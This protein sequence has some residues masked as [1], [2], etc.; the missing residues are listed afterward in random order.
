M[1]KLLL[2]LVLLLVL[3]VSACTN[4]TAEPT[5]NNPQGKPSATA[6]TIVYQS[7]NGPIHI[8]AR[9]K[10]II[11]L[12]NAPNVLALGG[13]LVGVDE[14]TKMNPLFTDKLTNV[15]TVSE[16]SLE[17]IVALDPDLIIT[18][19]SMKNTDKL[20]EIAPTIVYTWGKLD[21]LQQQLEI[22][23]VLSKEKETQAWIEDFKNRAA[24]IGAEIKAKAG[25][26]VTVSVIEYDTENYYV[27]G[28]NWAR[29]TEI[30][31]QAMELQMA[32]KAKKDALA[33]GYY[34]LSQEAIP[35]YAGDFIVLSRK[36][37]SINP[38]LQTET[39][40]SIP[41]VK[42]NRII[43][44]DTEESTYS[45]PTTLEHLLAIFKEQ[46]LAKS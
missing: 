35:E 11:A 31:Y 4:E 1:N 36:K 6:D 18:G 7:E 33:A 2:P 14:W 30:L 44:I 22:G 38:F 32:E 34:T 12:T 17:K 10:R 40:K 39:W 20:S 13:S 21:Y 19:A 23:K 5:T 3:V 41:A 26:N 43:E 29:G 46:F 9:P 37:G 8:P 16:D 42:H 15:E 27:F 25:E 45:D 24:A 28:N